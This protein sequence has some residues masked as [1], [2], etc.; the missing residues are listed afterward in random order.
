MKIRLWFIRETELARLYSKFDPTGRG[1]TEPNEGDLV[2]V[3]RS[4]V[5]HTSKRGKEH[6]LELPDWFVEKAGL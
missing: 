2:W 5:E 3:P 6:T 4:I 1:G